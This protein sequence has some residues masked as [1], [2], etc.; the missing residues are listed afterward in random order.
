MATE[1]GIKLDYS[2]SAKTVDNYLSLFGLEIQNQDKKH[3]EET[4]ARIQTDLAAR[5][6]QFEKNGAIKEIGA[7]FER[8]LLA[9]TDGGK[10]ARDFSVDENCV[11]CGTCSKVCPA[12]NITVTDKVAY[13]GNCHNCPACVHACPQT[14]THVKREKAPAAGAT[15]R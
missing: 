1:A 7:L 8:A 6:H 5:K 9:K 13:G 15:R 11:K 12:G 3:T 10:A 4:V 2:A 14:V